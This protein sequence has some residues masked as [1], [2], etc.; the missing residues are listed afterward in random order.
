LHKPRPES[1]KT[2]ERAHAPRPEIPN[3][4]VKRV[5]P[6]KLN[7]QPH[8]KLRESLDGISVR[9]PPRASKSL[10]ML[11]R[12]RTCKAG[13]I[14]VRD[15][16]SSALLT[17]VTS[18]RKPANRSLPTCCPPLERPAQVRAPCP[19]PVRCMQDREY[20]PCL[21]Q[22]PVSK[23]HL[24]VFDNQARC[25]TY[26]P[27]FTPLRCLNTCSQETIEACGFAARAN[28]ASVRCATSAALP[29]GSSADFAV[30]HR[31]LSSRRLV[32]MSSS[33]EL[34]DAHPVCNLRMI[35]GYQPTI[36]HL[37]IVLGKQ[38]LLCPD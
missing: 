30:A 32:G 28:I 10:E 20:R 38:P 5:W 2:T 23:R 18:V 3:Q 21:R 35:E 25:A 7:R 6:H 14:P 15:A 36:F 22:R 9:L 33:L 11:R 12:H 13:S 19:H 34:D 37:E 31:L 8:Q 27:Q 4:Q 29:P 26:A 1:S 16:A 17:H 24:A